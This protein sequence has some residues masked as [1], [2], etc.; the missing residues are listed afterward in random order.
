MRKET[1]MKMFED[2]NKEV[3]IVLEIDG[4]E[5]YVTDVI[6]KKKRVQ[7]KYTCPTLDEVDE[8][9]DNKVH[10]CI[11]KLIEAEQCKQSSQQSSPICST[12]MNTLSGLFRT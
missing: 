2:L 4:I 8:T 1:R 7:V 10:D 3:K 11:M 6:L 12:I 5:V 9:L